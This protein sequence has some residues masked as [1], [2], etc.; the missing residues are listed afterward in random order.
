MLNQ[1]KLQGCNVKVIALADVLDSYARK[2]KCELIITSG[3]RSPES[4]KAAGGSSKSLHMLGLA[5]DFCFS[6][7]YNIYQHVTPIYEMVR[8]QTGI[9]NGV[10]QMEVCRGIVNDR[11]VNHIHLAFGNGQ[12]IYFTGVYK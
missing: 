1:E 8:N 9:F 2:N 4:N 10:T 5:I 11:W 6:D 7:K 12:P 3:F